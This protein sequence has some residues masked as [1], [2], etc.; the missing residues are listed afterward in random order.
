MVEAPG[1]KSFLSGGVFMRGSASKTAQAAALGPQ[2]SADKSDKKMK[3][4][5]QD[6]QARDFGVT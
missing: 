6:A 3:P 4:D 5:G 2:Q 1:F